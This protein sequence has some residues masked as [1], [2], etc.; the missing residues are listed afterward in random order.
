MGR[1]DVFR[2]LREVLRN[3]IVAINKRLAHLIRAVSVLVANFG[4]LARGH[5]SPQVIL[6]ALTIHDAFII[7]DVAF[8]TGVKFVGLSRAIRIPR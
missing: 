4:S 2:L 7:I 1:R 6:E 5:L 3:Q 8:H